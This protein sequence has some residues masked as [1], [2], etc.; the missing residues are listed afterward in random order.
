MVWL[1]EQARGLLLQMEAPTA[2]TGVAHWEAL[3]VVTQLSG[4]IPV[5]RPAEA[6]ASMVSS[7]AALSCALCVLSAARCPFSSALAL[8]FSS[9]SCHWQTGSL[10]YRYSRYFRTVRMC[11]RSFA[12]SPSIRGCSSRAGTGAGAGSPPV[13]SGEEVLV[14]GTV[15]LFKERR[16]WD[17][18]GTK[19]AVDGTFQWLKGQKGSG[20]IS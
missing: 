5:G 2:P 15:L 3:A 1:R 6:M 20:H 8:S 17:P 7:I 13:V 16:W 10:L 19:T 14:D 4:G 9:L 11:P 18:V 12:I